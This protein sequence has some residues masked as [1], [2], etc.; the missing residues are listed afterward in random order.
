MT[1]EA[2]T[3]ELA[4]LRNLALSAYSPDHF[5][6]SR[7]WFFYARA[8]QALREFCTA[9]PEHSETLKQ[10]ASV[11]KA[12]APVPGSLMDRIARGVD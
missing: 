7:S 5:P 10:E 4:R 2:Y 6:G 12:A 9:H 11:S 3:V 1:Y 8:G